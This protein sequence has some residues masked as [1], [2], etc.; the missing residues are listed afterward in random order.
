M[1]ENGHIAERGNYAE[2]MAADST[3]ARLSREFGTGDLELEVAAKDD[4]EK[5]ED[6]D[7]AKGT[8]AGVAGPRQ[9]GKALMQVEERAVGAVSRSTYFS[10]LRAANGVVTVPLL[11]SSLILMAATIGELKG[12]DAQ[13]T[14]TSPLLSTLQHIPY[15]VA[16][17]EMG[18]VSVFL[19]G[20]LRGAWYRFGAVD[21]SHGRRLGLAGHL[22]LYFS[23]FGRD[24][25]C[26]LP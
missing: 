24:S 26:E 3:F 10:F 23:S 6:Q 4:E 15:L 16:G 8:G 14:L 20:H 18:T 22:S 19:L 25:K 5:T 12:F 7:R 17:R 9:A 11:V 2:L 13:P 1:L 21:I